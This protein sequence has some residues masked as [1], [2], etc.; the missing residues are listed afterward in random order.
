MA[1]EAVIKPSSRSAF[2]AFLIFSLVIQDNV[3]FQS[4]GR[5]GGIEVLNCRIERISS[6]KGIYFLGCLEENKADKR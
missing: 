5:C 2:Q 3:I 6:G 1:A 4:R